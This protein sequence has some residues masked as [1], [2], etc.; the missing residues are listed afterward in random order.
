MG[1]VTV[2]E[3]GPDSWHLVDPGQ[4]PLTLCPCCGL[5]FKS[6]R[7]AQLVADFINDNELTIDDLVRK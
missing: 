5:P 6:R 3:N 2:T 1:V 4:P 7:A